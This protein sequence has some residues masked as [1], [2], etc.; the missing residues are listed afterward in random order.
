MIC[1]CSACMDDFLHTGTF[2]AGP[3]LYFSSNIVFIIVI[4]SPKR[5]EKQ[6]PAKDD[7]KQHPQRVWSLQDKYNR[8]KQ[9]DAGASFAPVGRQ[10]N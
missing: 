6:A 7:L 5:K 1:L 4:M 9:I 2:S 8:I 10:N 3:P